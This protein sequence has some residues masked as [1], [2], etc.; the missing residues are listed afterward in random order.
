[1]LDSDTLI[2]AFCGISEAERPSGFTK[3]TAGD[4][5]T[6]LVV[7]TLNRAPDRSHR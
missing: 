6:P 4:P 2:V 1:M 3:E 7:T 5:I